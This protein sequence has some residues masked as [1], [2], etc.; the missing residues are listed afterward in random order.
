[1]PVLLGDLNMLLLSGGPERTN[2]E[3]GTLL[4]AVGLR[5]GRIQ[6]VATPCAV[7]EGSTA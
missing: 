3:Y 1:V 2:A 5:V 7:I 6:L 4:A